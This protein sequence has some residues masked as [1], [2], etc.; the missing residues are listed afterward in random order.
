MNEVNVGICIMAEKY[1]DSGIRDLKNYLKTDKVV[2]GTE[3]TVKLLKS[4]AAEKVFLSSNCP[5]DVKKDIEYYAKLSGAV[6][7]YLNQPNDELGTLCKKPY[8]V[9]VLSIMQ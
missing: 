9:S 6:L 7:V 4:G 2:L 3:K 1:V 5:E 8:S